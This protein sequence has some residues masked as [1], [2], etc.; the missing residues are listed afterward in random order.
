MS[1]LVWMLMLAGLLTAGACERKP[2]DRTP[3]KVT[4]EDVRRDAGQAVK[5]AAEFS[6][7]TK[8]EFQKKLEIQLNELDAKIAKLRE[9]GGDL[10]QATAYAEQYTS[11]IP[12]DRAAAVRLAGLYER[13]GRAADAKALRAGLAGKKEAGK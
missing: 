6:Q 5:T 2:A 8:E 1:R 13:T 3:G 12:D 9:K 11:E 10:K 7:Q 4:S